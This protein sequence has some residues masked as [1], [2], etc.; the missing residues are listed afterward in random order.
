MDTK[1]RRAITQTTG[2]RVTLDGE[3]G[4][5]TGHYD[6]DIVYVTFDGKD[7]PE[8]VYTEALALVMG[9]E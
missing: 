2:A 1:T 4:T 8:R 9:G 7:K 6:D 5:V 3:L